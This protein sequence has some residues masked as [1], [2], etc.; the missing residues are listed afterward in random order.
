MREVRI[1]AKEKYYAV[2][3]GTTTGIFTD[4]AAAKDST[5]F[6]PYGRRRKFDNIYAAAAY[7][8]LYKDFT[9]SVR[10]DSIKDIKREAERLRTLFSERDLYNKLVVKEVKKEN[11]VKSPGELSATDE[12]IDAE[13]VRKPKGWDSAD[14][15]VIT[16]QKEYGGILKSK[17][18]TSIAS[19]MA[20]TINKT[21]KPASTPVKTESA[22]IKPLTIIPN[23][24]IYTDGCY[25]Q[26]VQAR[27]Y[28][29]TLYYGTNNEPI[30][31]SGSANKGTSMEMEL[32]AVNKA[33]KRVMTY[34]PQGVIHIFTDSQQIVNT[35]TFL[36]YEGWEK[37]Q[38]VKN[39]KN[40]T[41]QRKLWKKIYK[42]VSKLTV[43]FHWVKG[44]T[45]NP[46]NEQC[47]RLAK[48]EAKLQFDNKML[49]QKKAS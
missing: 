22:A 30:V 25:V 16:Q 6:Y 15:A 29:A 1:M 35:M 42:K 43:E 21:P 11:T 23:W 48:L 37:Q 13:I 24:I 12:I 31:V 28:A 47:D 9:I 10:Q 32:M 19:V 41:L 27:G 45:G 3:R 33:L 20:G 14:R 44:H 5:E 39:D 38:D 34:N 7:L 4:P 8:H 49:K 40:N 18:P 36:V 17:I 26:E 2:A 46:R